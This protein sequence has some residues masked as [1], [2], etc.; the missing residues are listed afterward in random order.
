MVV[1]ICQL[2]FHLPGNRSL[3]GKRQVVKKLCD[4]IRSRFHVSVSEVG[5]QDRHQEAKIGVAL[6]SNDA[7][8]LNSLMDQILRVVESMQLA[9][10]LD[11]QFEVLHYNDEMAGNSLGELEDELGWAEDWKED[12]ESSTLSKDP[13]AYMES[14]SDSPSQ[15]ESSTS[16]NRTSQPTDSVEEI[17]HKKGKE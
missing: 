13:W 9:P 1:G 2:T 6:V 15:S 3:K 8:L 4:R 14:W 10:L 12:D 7:R 5:S 16:L 17:V 11:R